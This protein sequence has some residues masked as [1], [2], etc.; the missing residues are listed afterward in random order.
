MLKDLN[1][2]I[3]LAVVMFAVTGGSL[4][5]PILPEMMNLAGATSTNVGLALSAYTF[6]AMITTPLLGPVADRFGRKRVIVPAVMLFGVGGLLITFTRSFWLVLVWRALQGIGVGGMMN[7]VVAAIGDMYEEPDRSRAMGYRITVQGMTNALVPFVSGAIATVA[8]FL[9]FYIHSL[10]ILMAIFAAFKLQE[11]AGVATQKRY[12]RRALRAMARIRAIWLFFSN[13]L[14]FVLLYGIV[15]Y[16]PILVVEQ[17]GLTTLF[18]GL[19][20]SVAAGVSALVAS[21]AGRISKKFPEDFRVLWGFCCCGLS[22]LLAAIAP[23]YAVLLLFMVV[24]GLGFGVLMPTLNAAAAGLV[25][26]ELRAG[27]L[28]IFTLLIYLGQT[29]SPPFFAL[30]VHDGVIRGAFFA[31]SALALVPLLFTVFMIARRLVSAGDPGP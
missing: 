8:W 7:T 25:S 3:L 12:M 9:P 27:V 17:F 16:M 26:T 21:Q 11:P 20:I 28:S 14:A 4:V 13:F 29:V 30:F 24:W 19:A 5:G 6:S 2:L 23:G 10:A 15:V 22:H 18:S 31:G 1:L